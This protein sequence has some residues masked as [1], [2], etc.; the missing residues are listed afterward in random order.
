MKKIIAFVPVREGSK[1]IPLKNI[2]PLYGKPLLYWSLNALEKTGCI[3]EIIVATDSDEI[4]KVALSFG[5]QKIK[6]YRRLPENATDTASTESV[7]L[8]YLKTVAA[9]LCDDNI[10]VLVQATSPLTQSVH[11]EEAIALYLD[12]KYDSMLS[13]VRQKRFIWDE[14]G[15]PINYQYQ[16]RPRRQEF[17]GYLLENGAFYIN[18]TENIIHFENRLSGKIGIYEMPEYTAF[19]LDEE[20]DWIIIEKLMQCHLS[21]VDDKPRIKLFLTDVDG[22]LTD[23]GMYYSNSGDE[24]KKFNT[25][26]G[27][28][29]ELLREAGIKTGIITTENTKIV[30]NRARKLNVDYLVQGRNPGGKLASA[31]EICMKE[32]ITLHEVAYIGD[33]LNCADLLE[34]VGIKAC[35]A[36]ACEKVKRI[37][38][39]ITLAKKGGEGVVR[40]FAEKHILHSLIH[41]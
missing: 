13:C 26:D 9:D 3:D 4:E 23:G 6:I 18:R 12:K 2:K 17:D 11:F 10:L 22:V 20:N 7:L 28:A 31:R 40:E 21:D 19:E 1:S 29:F 34:A 15:T 38:G 41:P 36:D 8:E 37:P 33:D 39:I 25:R 5:F 14:H 32:A 24:W 27:V 35:P 30:A 16:K